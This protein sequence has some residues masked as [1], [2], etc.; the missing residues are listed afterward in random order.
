MVIDNPIQIYI[1]LIYGTR[2]LEALRR[3]CKIDDV[4]SGSGM[5][6]RNVLII[7]IPKMYNVQKVKN[8]PE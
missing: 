4:T 2:R 3:R 7:L 6:F 1:F 8:D 5:F